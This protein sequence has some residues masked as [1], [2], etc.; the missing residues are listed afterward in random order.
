MSNINNKRRKFFGLVGSASLGA[1]LLSLVPFRSV[2][3]NTDNT[4][5][6]KTKKLQVEIHPLAVKRTK[7]G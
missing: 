5:N 2:G 4:A 3:K 1:A 7:K 6:D